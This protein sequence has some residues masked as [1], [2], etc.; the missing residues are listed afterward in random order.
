[1]ISRLSTGSEP[2]PPL[3]GQSTDLNDTL[4]RLI[5]GRVDIQLLSVYNQLFGLSRTQSELM[6]L[7][8]LIDSIPTL[9]HT[10]Q[11]HGDLDYFHH[12]WPN[13]LG[14]TLLEDLQ[15]WKWTAAIHPEELQGMLD[16]W[17]AAYRM[18]AYLWQRRTIELQCT[19]PPVDAFGLHCIDDRPVAFNWAW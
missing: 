6:N 2:R 16:K 7:Q 9:I 10:G 3:S 4:P 11:P 13:Y 18:R 12:A 19:L 5:C 14:L 15:G 8:L 17:R 1:M